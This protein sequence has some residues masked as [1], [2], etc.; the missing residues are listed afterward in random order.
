MSRID[1]RAADQLRPVV[2]Q[3]NFTL[4]APG[5]VLIT[6]GKPKLFVRLR[7][8]KKFLTFCGAKAKAG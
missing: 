5:S 7:L 2:L 6:M 3:T 1:D 8:K 4:Y